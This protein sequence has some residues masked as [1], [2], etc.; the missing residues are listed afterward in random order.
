MKSTTL[1][2]SCTCVTNDDGKV[3]LIHPCSK[4]AMSVQM[5]LQ[6]LWISLRWQFK[7]DEEERLKN[8]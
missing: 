1:G 2:C 6:D 8:A 4:H 7:I 3:L 5:E